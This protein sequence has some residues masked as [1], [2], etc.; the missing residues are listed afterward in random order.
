MPL[1]QR[2]VDPG[3]TFSSQRDIVNLSDSDSAFPLSHGESRGSYGSKPLLL[4]S[5][6]HPSQFQG[7]GFGGLEKSSSLGELRGGGLVPGP[8]PAAAVLASSSST[9]SLCVASAAAGPIPADEDAGDE[10]ESSVSRRRNA[11]NKVFKKKQGRH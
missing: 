8:A 1:R 4:S 2:M 9:R 10:S 7:S 11:F 6:L 5:R 3:L